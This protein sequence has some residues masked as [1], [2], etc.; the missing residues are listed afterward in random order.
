MDYAIGA[1]DI[2]FDN[3]GAVDLQAH[4]PGRG[5]DTAGAVG[6]FFGGDVKQLVGKC[7]QCGHVDQLCG[8]KS[9]GDYVI[10]EDIREAFLVFGFK[11]VEERD[12]GHPGE[13]LVG[14]GKNGKGASAFECL[15][16]VGGLEGFEQHCEAAVI[17]EGFDYVL[18]SDTHFAVAVGVVPV[19]AVAVSVATCE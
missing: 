7:H 8:G 1:L 12:F 14:G 11:Q 2:R 13:G 5:G 3:I 4:R 19:I 17:F 10:F 16:Q 9:A 18:L 6:L 15:G